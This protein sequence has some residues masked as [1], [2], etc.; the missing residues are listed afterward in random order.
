M[1]ETE[2]A[3]YFELVSNVIMEW[4]LKGKTFILP[5]NMGEFFILKIKSDPLYTDDKGKI[6]VKK[7]FINWRETQKL[8]K[9]KEPDKSREYWLKEEN[10]YKYVVPFQDDYLYRIYYKKPSY[11]GTNI[12]R[13][14]QFFI[15][16]PSGLFKRKLAYLLKN[17]KKIP[18]Y[19]ETKYHNN[20]SVR[21]VT[22]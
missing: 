19:Y 1:V 9:R 18:S 5:F 11:R 21:K 10:S 13:I 12:K 22:T 7:S 2:Y 17:S 6:R 8:R 14:N 15:F 16:K 20:S 3:K 4:V